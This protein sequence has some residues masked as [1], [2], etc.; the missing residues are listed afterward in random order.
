MNYTHDRMAY[1]MKT[2]VIF[3]NKLGLSIQPGLVRGSSSGSWPVRSRSWGRSGG[4]SGGR[5]RLGL[6]LGLRVRLGLGLGLGV[7]LGLRLRIRLGLGV[8]RLLR[9]LSLALVGD[10]GL[11]T[12]V[13]V[14]SVH[15]LLP[16]A[17]RELDV[18]LARGEF[19]VP[20]LLVTK[21][22]ARVVVLHL[23]LEAILGRMIFTILRLR[24]I[25]WLGPGVRGSWSWSRGRSR[26]IAIPGSSSEGGIER[27]LLVEALV[28]W[29]GRGNGSQDG[30]GDKGLE[31]KGW[32]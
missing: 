14:N 10:L 25:G 26:G 28:G 5:V 20:V 12:I 27:R 3:V 19:V 8:G 6:G 22:V 21:I 15:D 24:R 31:I 4:G 7:G 17:V 13:A 29:Q 11:V 23:P 18:V 16:T 1:L 30:K 9:V 32:G 2:V